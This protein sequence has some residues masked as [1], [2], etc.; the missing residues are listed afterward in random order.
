[1]DSTGKHITASAGDY[2]LRVLDEGWNRRLLELARIS[3]VTTDQIKIHF[4]RSPDI[5]TIPRLTSFKYRCLGLF[6][7]DNLVGYAIASYQRRYIDGEA[8]DVLYLGNMHVIERGLGKVFLEKL[9]QRYRRVVPESTEVEYLYAYVIGKN[10]PAMKLVEAG[11]LQSGA[12]G[13]IVMDTIFLIIPKRLS[14]KYSV[15]FARREDMDAIVSLLA[16]EHQSRFL[17]PVFDR[18]IFLENLSQRPNFSI[19]NY[20]VALE[21]DQ[22]VGACSAWDMTSF[23]RNRVLAYGRKLSLIRFVY[24]LAALLFGSRRLPKSGETFRDITIAEYAVRDR[25]PEIMEALLRFLYRHYRN[26]GFQSLIFGSSIDDPLLKATET[27]ITNRVTSNVILAS[28]EG[29]P[30]EQHEGKPLIY[31]DAIQI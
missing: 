25:D 26:R 6:K 24:N 31:A 13:E 4:D 19:E 14:T 23:K 30:L 18:E 20:V 2:R 12:I 5:F 17:A 7:Q 28:H 1:M 22:I 10:I 21:N 27:F 3:P 9:S 11:H 16:R 15:R 29:N 8:A